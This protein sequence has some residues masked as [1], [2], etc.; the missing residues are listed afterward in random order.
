MLHYFRMK[1]LRVSLCN[2]QYMFDLNIHF[3]GFSN[4]NLIGIS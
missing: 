4:Q 1:V 2:L 3:D